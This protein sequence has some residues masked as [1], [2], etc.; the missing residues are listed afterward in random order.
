MAAERKRDGEKKRGDK[1]RAEISE[2]I[3]L[4]SKRSPQSGEPFE[5]LPTAVLLPPPLLMLLLL[6]FSPIPHYSSS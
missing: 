6:F 3:K 4:A 2:L 5:P 1:K